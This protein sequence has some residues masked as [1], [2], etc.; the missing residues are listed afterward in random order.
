MVDPT[1]VLIKGHEILDEVLGP[2][3]FEFRV[4]GPGRGSG[5]DFARGSYVRGDRRLELHV[6]YSLGLV[7][8]HVGN[9]SIGHTDLMECV[10]GPRNDAQYPG[11]SADPLDGFRHLK[12]D[13]QRYGTDFLE[14]SE[15][16]LGR[17]ARSAAAKP[18]GFKRIAAVEA[19]A[20]S[21]DSDAD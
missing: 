14:G 19:A 16:L 11:I 9:H 20:V 1:D 8:Y 3:G 2:N 21:R 13:L 12:A 4:E 6:R 10:A 15:E 17:Y 5:G 18:K 7:T